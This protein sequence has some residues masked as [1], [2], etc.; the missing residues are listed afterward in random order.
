MC[1]CLFDAVYDF[2]SPYSMEVKQILCQ[3][4]RDRDTVNNDSLRVEKQSFG[5]RGIKL[6]IGKKYILTV[7]YISKEKILP[8]NIIEQF[9]KAGYELQ[10]QQGNPGN[11]AVYEFKKVNGPYKDNLS[12]MVYIRN[13]T[14]LAIEYQ[15]TT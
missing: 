15:Y 9:N 10:K 4:W 13:S 1:S 14:E 5:K 8:I 7:E 11:E 6:L 12:C 2:R 3:E